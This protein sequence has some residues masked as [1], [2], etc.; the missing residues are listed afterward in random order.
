MRK[1]LE[2]IQ[3]KEF[4]CLFT[5]YKKNK[6]NNNKTFNSILRITPS[7]K[8]NQIT[9]ND[10]TS[11]TYLDTNINNFDKNEKEY[12]PHYYLSYHKI[13]KHQKRIKDKIILTS[14]NQPKLK[15]IY[16][17]ILKKSDIDK[18]KMDS[19]LFSFDP[20]ECIFKYNDNIDYNNLFEDITTKNDRKIDSLKNIIYK[21]NTVE[22]T[23]EIKNF[24]NIPND[25]IISHTEDLIKQKLNDNKEN[26][27]KLKM[28][29]NIINKK[30]NNI[31]FDWVL[32][33]IIHK[34][35]VKNE[36]NVHI[37]SLW[38]KNLINSFLGIF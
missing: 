13:A 7:L 27:N 30:V 28:K 38:V 19:S 22:L 24:V 14:Q 5:N 26:E 6:N 23:N 3:P 15:N 21:M 29:D 1:N 16:L 37:S 31:F 12:I 20:E 17:S 2:L 33:N 34:I 8:K 9:N 10:I 35:E 11:K 32:N 4:N 36:K 18:C 25:L